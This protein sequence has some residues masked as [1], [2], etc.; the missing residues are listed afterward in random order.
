VGSNLGILDTM[1]VASIV[2]V[3]V[4]C[5]CKACVKSGLYDTG[6]LTGPHAERGI[7]VPN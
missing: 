6:L 1:L 2:K 5:H 3:S 4:L 7:V